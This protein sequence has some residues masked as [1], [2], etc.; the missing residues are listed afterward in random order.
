MDSRR[1]LP[2]RPV[3]EAKAGVQEHQALVIEN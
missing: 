1:E 2:H 3:G